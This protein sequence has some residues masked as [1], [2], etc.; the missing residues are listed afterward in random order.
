M[1]IAHQF[2][3]NSDS[4]I[5]STS[6]CESILTRITQPPSD[7]ESESEPICIQL[8]EESVSQMLRD[9]SFDFVPNENPDIEEYMGLVEDDKYVGWNK[10]KK[11]CHK[12]SLPPIAA[13]KD[14]LEGQSTR[15]DLNV[16]SSWCI[17]N[18]K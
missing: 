13:V 16:R 8:Y 3:F 5:T 10:Y 11:E 18:R 7:E 12:Y 14:I 2:T 4:T 17:F 9:D 1:S 6:G 15:F